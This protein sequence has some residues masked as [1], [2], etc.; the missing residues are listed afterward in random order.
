MKTLTPTTHEQ[1]VAILEVG[2]KL[3]AL[4]EAF[5]INT[6]GGLFEGLEMKIMEYISKQIQFAADHTN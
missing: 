6:D 4:T 3:Y 1:E 2:D 5:G